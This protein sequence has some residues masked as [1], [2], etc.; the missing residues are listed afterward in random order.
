MEQAPPPATESW[1]AE[2]ATVE[3][4][5]TVLRSTGP[6]GWDSAAAV[7]VLTGDV[8]NR[9][10]GD[11]RA[12][13]DWWTFVPLAIIRLWKDLSVQTRIAV[14]LMALGQFKAECVGPKD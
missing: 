5:Q 6:G 13:K 11:W 8:E 2:P 12:V 7:A 10:A 1:T 9:F 3:L 14:Y 4:L